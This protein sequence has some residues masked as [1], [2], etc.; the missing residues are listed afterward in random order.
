MWSDGANL[1]RQPSA[2]DAPALKPNK[3]KTQWLGIRVSRAVVPELAKC[4]QL[5]Q[6]GPGPT[7]VSDAES[8]HRV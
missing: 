7:S 3:I 8:C 4:V 1:N 6:L 2:L 5:Q